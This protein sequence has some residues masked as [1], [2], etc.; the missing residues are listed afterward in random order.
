MTT[1]LIHRHLM[2]Q[3]K[4]TVKILKIHA[5]VW[6][7]SG[8]TRLHY[9]FQA[10]AFLELSWVG[11]STKILMPSC[12]MLLGL[13][14]QAIPEYTSLV[15][16]QTALR[17]KV[18]LQIQF[19]SSVGFGKPRLESMLLYNKYWLM[20]HGKGLTKEA[21][22]PFLFQAP[23]SHRKTGSYQILLQIK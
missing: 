2:V 12:F 14:Q 9:I 15:W 22:K 6:P 5:W 1:Q 16:H 7:V 23:S 21:E 19:K 20:Q 3:S 11:F 4:L 8:E 13:L 10:L 18:C 17:E